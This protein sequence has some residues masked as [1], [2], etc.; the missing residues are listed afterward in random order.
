MKSTK[1]RLTDA[2]KKIMIDNKAVL[3]KHKALFQRITKQTTTYVNTPVRNE[4][5]SVYKLIVP[6]ECL[7]GCGNEWVRRLAVWYFEEI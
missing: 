7:H 2:Q 6:D 5:K 1:S 4:L 3:D